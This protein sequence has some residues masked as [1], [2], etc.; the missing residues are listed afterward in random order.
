MM[1]TL[2]NLHV[3]KQPQISANF[4][5]SGAE[6]RERSKNVDVDLTRVSLRGDRIG[7]VKAG[8]LGDKLV[9]PFD[10]YSRRLTL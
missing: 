7:V 5:C 9:E 2:A 8:E 10:L 4:V 1:V 6:G 3:S